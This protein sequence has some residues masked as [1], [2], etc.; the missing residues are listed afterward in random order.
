MGKGDKYLD[1]K[2]KGEIVQ[3]KRKS[4]GSYIITRILS[5]NPS[6]YLRKAQT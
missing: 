3:L 2:Y 1:V 4:D 5:T 6:A